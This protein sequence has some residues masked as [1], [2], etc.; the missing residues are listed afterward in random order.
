MLKIEYNVMAWIL[1]YLTSQSENE[2]K[3]CDV[4]FSLLVFSQEE[5]PEMLRKCKTV[6]LFCSLSQIFVSVCWVKSQYYILFIERGRGKVKW[7][8]ARFFA[9]C[10]SIIC[11]SCSCSP[12]DHMSFCLCTAFGSFHA[13]LL[14]STQFISSTFF[15][16]LLH[17]RHWLS[18]L[19]LLLRLFLI[20]KK[21]A[22]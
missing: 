11:V 4:M 16:A 20:M 13:N 1:E 14:F 9:S 21:Y 5:Y 19:L 7:F 22:W 12:R 3:L 18:K 8:D 17:E 15:W 6:Q 2:E 10:Q